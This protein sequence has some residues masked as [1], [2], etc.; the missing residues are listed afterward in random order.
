M[1]LHP[2]KNSLVEFPFRKF[3]PEKFI[4]TYP[5]RPASGLCNQLLNVCLC[6]ETAARTNRYAALGPFLPSFNSDEWVSM[7]RVLDF[8][9]TQKAFNKAA[10]HVV[11]HSL[12]YHKLLGPRKLIK[13]MSLE[14]RIKRGDEVVSVGHLMTPHKELV[15]HLRFQP[16][17]Y[18]VVGLVEDKLDLKQEDWLAL[19]LRLEDDMVGRHAP[20]A[21][22]TPAAYRRRILDCYMAA[23]TK[24][25]ENT[26]GEQLKRVFVATGL[27]VDSP[28]MQAFQ[29]ACPLTVLYV[30][31]PKHIETETGLRGR[32]LSGLVDL[33]IA[34]KA[35]LGCIGFS[36][37]SMSSILVAKAQSDGRPAVLI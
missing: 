9:A 27:A 36:G 25:S 5:M 22:M 23:I 35:P 29:K 32:E 14:A 6:I 18:R 33:L 4:S 10:I 24:M 1:E 2:G 21:R 15:W 12:P 3:L 28:T 16:G 30:D 8:D 17:F 31:D 13:A 37:S 34:A 26:K 11:F 7:D 20:K 19:H